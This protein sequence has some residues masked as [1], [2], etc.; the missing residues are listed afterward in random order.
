MFNHGKGA[1]KKDGRK[2]P[3]QNRQKS[4][5]M[6]RIFDDFEM[7]TFCHPFSVRL[8]R[9][10]KLKKASMHKLR[11]FSV[12]SKNPGHIANLVVFGK[13]VVGLSV[14]VI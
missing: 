14:R 13:P 4:Y 3:F 8:Y 5:A 6:H 7:A 1:R 2:L 9:G 12:G 10:C 11:R